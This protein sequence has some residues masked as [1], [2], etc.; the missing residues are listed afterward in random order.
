VTGLILIGY[1][2]VL[3]LSF[4][5]RG[6]KFLLYCFG[7]HPVGTG[8]S[9]VCG[10]LTPHPSRADLKNERSQTSISAN[11]IH[12]LQS[13]RFTLRNS[14]ELYGVRR[15]RMSVLNQKGKVIPLQARCGPEGG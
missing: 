7:V 8:G 12:N 2:V 9:V 5:D 3:V 4:P 13:D 10:K 14:V 15:V 11:V 1:S 6:R